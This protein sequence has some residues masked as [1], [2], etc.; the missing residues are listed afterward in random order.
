MTHGGEGEL[1]LAHVNGD[2]LSVV[3]TG[4]A[5]L[6]L[7]GITATTLSELTIGGGA[8]VGVYT[9]TTKTTEGT[10]TIDAAGVLTAGDS[11]L[12]AN[13]VME[14]DSTL[15]TGGVEKALHVGSTLTMGSNIALDE[16]TL[17]K[18]DGLDNKAYFWLIDAAEDSELLYGGSTGEDAWFDEVFSRTAYDG[19]YELKGDFNI[20]FDDV[21]GF[22]LQKFSSVPE[23]M[24]G[25][26]SL[27]ALM[28]LA[29]RRRKH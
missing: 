24:T 27:L 25:T 3:E 7:Q 8:T 23:P 9:D 12:L 10:V 5:D 4:T 26:L 20:V 11:T 2:A 28:A 19:D 16:A 1:T 21:N 29:A 17:R 13:L 14:D 6:I 22:G 18:L 15:L